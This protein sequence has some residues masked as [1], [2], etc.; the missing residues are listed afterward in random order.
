MKGDPIP[1]DVCFQRKGWKRFENR[2]VHKSDV[3]SLEDGEESERE[4]RRQEIKRKLERQLK[5]HLDTT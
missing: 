5:S 1:T 2:L 3:K 4:S